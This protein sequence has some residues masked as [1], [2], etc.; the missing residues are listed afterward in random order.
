MQLEA[1]TAVTNASSYVDLQITKMPF[2]VPPP[3]ATHKFLNTKI[4]Y[5][6]SKPEAKVCI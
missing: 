3:P 5:K 4:S 2:S 6:D 1:G